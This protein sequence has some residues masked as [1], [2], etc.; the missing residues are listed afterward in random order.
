MIFVFGSI[1]MD[2]VANVARLPGPG[3]TVKGP[4]YRTVPGGKGA[5]QA[6]AAARAGASVALLG[7]VGDD[8]FRDPAL[9]LL[10]EAGVDVSDV[11]VLKDDW[12]GLAMIAVDH[13]AENQIVVASGANERALP[14][15]LA[16]RIGCQD[17]LL[18]QYELPGPTVAAAARIAKTRGARVVL[19]AAPAGPPPSGL[20]DYVDILV[21]NEHEATVIAKVEGTASDFR[22]F[23]MSFSSAHSAAVIVTLGARGAL[24]VHDGNA[25][26]IT[27]PGVSV[28]D[29]TGAGDAFI[30]ALAAS[31]DEGDSLQDALNF[32]V[33]AGSL[34]TTKF[35]SQTS[36]PHR[37]EISRTLS[38]R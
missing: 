3:E 16:S 36:L 14:H 10:R 26:E 9:E 4:A 18:L 29:T 22:S 15:P 34:A 11:A 21:V 33:V 1:N 6:L 24:L 27:A 19:N 13:S 37:A 17:T 35:G 30:G 23:A 31:I 5:N 25:F 28:V 2:I 12:T 8:R 20:L 38:L 32:A 7:A